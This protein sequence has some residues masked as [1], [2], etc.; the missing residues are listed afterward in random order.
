LKHNHPF[1]DGAG[2]IREHILMAEKAL[3]RYLKPP[4]CTHHHDKV[5]G[6][7]QRGNIV[8]CQDQGYHMLLH[9][10]MRALAACGNANFRKCKICKEY[11]RP[12]NL[13]YRKC[14]GY[15]HKSCW[16][17]RARKKRL[18]KK[19]GVACSGLV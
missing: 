6:N 10:R 3:G 12:D 11:D 7:N 5:K 9:Q 13:T 16:A 14:G 18:L 19:E 4:E 15:L 1:A 2:Y 8:V 17:E